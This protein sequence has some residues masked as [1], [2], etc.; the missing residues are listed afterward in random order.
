MTLL[1]LLIFLSPL[2]STRAR[3]DD[4]A[5]FD[6]YDELRSIQDQRWT[7]ALEQARIELGAG[8]ITPDRLITRAREIMIEQPRTPEERARAAARQAEKELHEMIEHWVGGANLTIWKRLAHRPGTCWTRTQEGGII[9]KDLHGAAVVL[10]TDRMPLQVPPGEEATLHPSRA[11]EAV[12]RQFLRDIQAC[13]PPPPPP[14]PA[15]AT[16]WWDIDLRSG[17]DL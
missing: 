10:H 4:S 11:L 6:V 16:P 7:L 13:T 14:A 15:S 5:P 12:R 9:I 3:A 17:L 8:L 1:T 2:G